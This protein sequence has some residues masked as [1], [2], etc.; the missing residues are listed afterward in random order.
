MP[1]HYNETVQEVVVDNPVYYDNIIN[2]TVEIPVERVI[3]QTFDVV[4]EVRVERQVDRPVYIDNVIE[5]VVEVPVEHVVENRYDV[6]VDQ[7]Y[8]TERVKE[9]RYPVD[10]VREVTVEEIVENFVDR[11]VYRENII[12]KQVENIVEVP[13]QQIVEVPVYVDKIVEVP[14]YVDRVHENHYEIVRENRYPVENIVNIPVEKIVTEVVERP[15]EQVTE[16]PVEKLVEVKREV[17]VD[18][19]VYVDNVIERTVEIDNPIYVDV[20]HIV[21]RPV[22][23]E[24]ITEKPVYIEKVIEK[25]VEHVVEKIVEVPIEQIVTVPVEVIVERPVMVEKIV[26]KPVYVEQM[27]EKPIERVI[28]IDEEVDIN[29][30]LNWEENESRI[31]TLKLEHDRLNGQL[32]AL[33][34]QLEVYQHGDHEDWLS[35]NK[36]MRREIVELEAELLRRQRVDHR[37]EIHE[38]VTT[39]TYQEDPKAVEFRRQIEKL[40]AENSVLTQKIGFHDKR[41][42]VGTHNYE[43]VQTQ[44]V[45]DLGMVVGEK[46]SLRKSN[47][48]Q[49]A[50]V[51]I[52]NQE[53]GMPTS[54]FTSSTFNTTTTNQLYGTTGLVG[55]MAG[56]QSNVV[57]S[58]PAGFGGANTYGSRVGGSI[59]GGYTSGSQIGGGYTTGSQVGGIHTGNRVSHASNVVGGYT[60]GSTVVGGS[61]IQSSN[62]MTQGSRVVGGTSG[63][64]TGDRLSHTSGYRTQTSVTS[65]NRY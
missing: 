34:L 41:I 57:S 6:V 7:P 58:N 59:V 48:G 33:G 54:H 31:T 9:N 10:R 2:K 52:K 26:E 3:E 8:Y 17:I 21:E 49:N 50:D 60:T 13:V 36:V 19:P 45:D 56:R 12:H 64:V 53:T 11:P 25:P 61:H 44:L 28:E 47:R 14:V 42:S 37:S 4:R 18:K 32:V 15:Y 22:Y 23:T 46:R 38:K 30:K 29:L 65:Q 63:V 16:V 43:S 20:E 55:S 5:Q 27:I 40:K 35:K 51:D 24:K 39:I 62:V 1:T